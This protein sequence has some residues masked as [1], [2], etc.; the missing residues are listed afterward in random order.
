MPFKNTT[1]LKA[2]EPGWGSTKSDHNENCSR[3]EASSWGQKVVSGIEAAWGAK[4]TENETKKGREQVLGIK[5]RSVGMRLREAQRIW[6][7]KPRR[8]RDQSAP[9]PPVVHP[10]STY[11]PTTN[12]PPTYHEFNGESFEDAIHNLENEFNGESGGDNLCGKL[13]GRVE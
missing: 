2:D 12:A 1:G 10:P 13:E 9:A 3:L 7:M 4:K 8:V 6:K 5:R 11:T